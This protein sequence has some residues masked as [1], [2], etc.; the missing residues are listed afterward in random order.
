MFKSL[1]QLWSRDGPLPQAAE[2][3]DGERVYAIGDIHGECALFEAL[4]GAIEADDAARA[5]AETTVVLLGDLIDRGPRS[6]DVIAAARSWQARRQ[7]RIILGNHEEMFLRSFMD[8]GTFRQFM[9]HGGRET[10]LSYPIDGQAFNAATVEEA[11]LMMEQVVPDED[12]E[13]LENFEDFIVIGDY[14]FVHAGIMPGEPLLGQSPTTTRWIREPFLSH[15]E[16]H[17]HV[18]VHG[19]TIADAPVIAINR[20]GIDTGA[21][22]SGR[23][24]AIGLESRE[25]WL[26]E[27]IAHDDGA[28]ETTTRAI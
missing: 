25:G 4:I 9:V 2:I 21:Y 7:V 28:I 1:R 16:P 22:R 12:R 23:L 17:A 14:L 6:A 19:H 10:L 26:I 18:V 5:A 20:I 3:P 24:T 27:A 13:F 15:A 8:L 11:Q